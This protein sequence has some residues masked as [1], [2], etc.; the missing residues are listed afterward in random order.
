MGSPDGRR[1]GGPRHR[2]RARLHPR[3]SA[4]T[5]DAIEKPEFADERRQ[6]IVDI[7][8]ARGR[9]RVRDLAALL[10]V[11]EPTVRKDITDLAA[12]RLLKR[13]HGAAVAITPSNE[14]DISERVGTN[15][16]A[17][18]AIARACL[19]EIVDGDA[20]FFDSG[21]T[22]SALARLL[23]SPGPE[24]F[25]GVRVPRN[26]NVLT[27][28]IDVARLL[29]NS[30]TRH[31]VVGGQYRSAGGSFVGPLAISALQQFTL[32]TAF[33]GVSGLN[34]VGLTVADLSEA[35]VKRTAMEQARRVIVPMD[36]SK[37]GVSDFAIVCELGNVDVL[38]T[39]QDDP[40]LERLCTDHDVT[41]VVAK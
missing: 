9:V 12:A 10:R 6:R 19:E 41:V 11:T 39:D 15:A 29:A 40:E 7:V 5:R 18:A 4:R 1:G 16:A 35:Q 32:N 21:T 31:T 13:V 26:V 30:P 14:V 28:S 24:R 2:V 37:M 8:Q 38:I 22:V 3:T 33:I 34:E 25:D 23:G 20:V 36:S 27:N 17:K